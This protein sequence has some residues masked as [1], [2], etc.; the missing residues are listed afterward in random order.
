MLASHEMATCLWVV[1]DGADLDISVVRN[2][3]PIPLFCIEE[4]WWKTETVTVA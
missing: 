3:H 2:H 1:M 4:P